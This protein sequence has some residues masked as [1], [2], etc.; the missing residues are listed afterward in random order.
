MCVVMAGATSK[1]AKSLAKRTIAH[2]EDSVAGLHPGS[3]HSGSGLDDAK[4]SSCGGEF[5][6]DQAAERIRKVRIRGGSRAPFLSSLTG[7]S[8]TVW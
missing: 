2:D 1:E 7:S 6:D 4:C 5:R 8:T 3:S